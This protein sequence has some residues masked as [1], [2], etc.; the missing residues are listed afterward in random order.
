MIK[1]DIPSNGPSGVSVRLLLAVLFLAV[2]CTGCLPSVK[3]IDGGRLA[4]EQYWRGRIDIF[5]DVE[6]VAGS[7]L[8]IAPG[9]DIVFHPAPPE[10]DRWRDHPHFPGS[11]LVIRGD[12]RAEG[13]ASRPIRFRASVADAPAGSWGGINI[14]SS[15][16][17]RIRHA[18]F[19]GADS[20]LHIQES[21]ASI[22]D[23]VFSGNLVAIR[24]HSSNILID[25]NRIVDN[26]TGIRFHFGAPVIRNNQISNN[27]R[28]LFITAHP[29][30]LRIEN[31]SFIANRDYDVVLGEEVPEDIQFGGNWWG[32]TDVRQVSPRIYDRE[33]DDL[34]GRVLLRP[35]RESPVAGVGPR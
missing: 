2:I 16:S 17:T 21:T 3:R 6:L 9:S 25:H 23:S 4:G 13:T 1:P 34:L 32:T 30:D 5:G 8:V 31:N 14:S 18:V 15:P 10:L 22:E 26:D 12:F 24:F 20:A 28:G 11:E 7:S 33:R 29:R 19:S 27:R 35:L